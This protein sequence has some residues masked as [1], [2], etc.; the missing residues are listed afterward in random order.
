M[1]RTLTT[2]LAALALCAAALL[3]TGVASAAPASGIEGLTIL[4]QTGSPSGSATP[5]DSASPSGP[6]DPGTGETR[7]AKE[8]RVDYTPY[9][10]GALVIVVLL[11]ATVVWRRR[12]GGGPSS[13]GP[14]RA[15]S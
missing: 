12:G 15:D 1:Y 8:T 4:S 13:K 11:G 6:V 7:E 10:V 5:T 9:V 3:T 14:R 2:A